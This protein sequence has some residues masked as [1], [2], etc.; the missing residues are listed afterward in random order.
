MEGEKSGEGLSRS[1]NRFST[2]RSTFH[3]DTFLFMR[4]A[5]RRLLHLLIKSTR[6]CW[7]SSSYDRIEGTK[8]AG[9]QDCDGSMG[10][11]FSMIHRI[12]MDMVTCYMFWIGTYES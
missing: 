8:A 9:E 7:R 10:Q 5:V 2:A 11:H 4:E 12:T 3:N 1:Q 6:A